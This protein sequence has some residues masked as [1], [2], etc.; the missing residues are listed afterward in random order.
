MLPEAGKTREDLVHPGPF[1]R[2]I[3]K[4]NGPGVPPPGHLS[5]ERA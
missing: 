2:K 1:G 3:S 5:R 4:P